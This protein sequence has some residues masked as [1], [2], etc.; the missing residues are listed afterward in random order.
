ME[1]LYTQDDLNT[2]YDELN[3]VV[4]NLT[5]RNAALAL[6]LSQEKTKALQLQNEVERLNKPTTKKGK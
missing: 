4:Q 1:K 6:S 5:Q 3:S 2:I